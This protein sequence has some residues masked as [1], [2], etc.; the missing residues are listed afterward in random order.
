MLAL[1]LGAA[2]AVQPGHGK[3]LVTAIAIGPG[4]RLYQP[5][6]LGLATT[7]AHT[8]SVLVIAA[9]LWY[10]GATRVGALH[11]VLAKAAGF[12]IAAAGFWRIGRFLGGF[13]VH[14]QDELKGGA[15]SNR[16]LL[17]LGLAG[18]AVPCWDAVGLLVLAAAI[19]RLGA[20]IGLVLAF[21]VGMGVVLVVLGA[22]A[23]KLKS[24][25][26]GLAREPNWER[27]LGLACGIML[28]AI[29]LVLFFQS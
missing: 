5:V 8:G 11:T 20:G 6:F 4:A 18:G 10:T 28:A 16:T 7:L 26:L 17:G 15:I 23:W 9:A 2:H 12:A 3:T 13:E 1:L 21:S 27:G 19:G 22:F 24:T 29:G 25:T 14:D